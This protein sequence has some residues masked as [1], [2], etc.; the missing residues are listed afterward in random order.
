MGHAIKNVKKV[1]VQHPAVQQ[2][3]HRAQDALVC[4]VIA[5]LRATHIII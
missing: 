5:I 1:V 2:M 4:S 3:M